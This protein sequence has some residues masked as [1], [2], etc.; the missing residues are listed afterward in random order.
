[1]KYIAINRQIQIQIINKIL[2]ILWIYFIFSV[3]SNIHER[4]YI[5]NVEVL[6]AGDWRLVANSLDVL[7]NS[8]TVYREIL[9]FL[10]RISLRKMG[11]RT[12]LSNRRTLMLEQERPQNQTLE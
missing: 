4:R 10:E 8:I 12:A 11:H 3:Y 5:R 2:V 9:H 7:M 6:N 1:M